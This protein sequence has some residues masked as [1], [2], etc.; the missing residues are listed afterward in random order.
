MQTYQYL[1][2]GADER[3]F[4]NRLNE[5]IFRMSTTSRILRRQTKSCRMFPDCTGRV[6]RDS[7]L[8][9]GGDGAVLG[10][11][12][13]PRA[14]RLPQRESVPPSLLQDSHCPK[15]KPRP[16]LHSGCVCGTAIDGPPAAG[17]LRL[18][19]AASGSHSTVYTPI[20]SMVTAGNGANHTEIAADCTVLLRA[21]DARNGGAMNVKQM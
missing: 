11:V 7:G 6:E 10:G 2:F 18:T 8:W 21:G 16:T 14:S 19:L 17:E 5:S 15:C 20:R 3:G 13:P 12:V 9:A 1:G 4:T